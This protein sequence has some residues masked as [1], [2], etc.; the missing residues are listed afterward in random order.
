V[1]RIADHPMPCGTKRAVLLYRSTDP[2]D[3]QAIGVPLRDRDT[4]TLVVRGDRDVYLPV[5]QA[6]RAA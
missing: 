4:D 5:A 2:R 6:A 3:T 1:H